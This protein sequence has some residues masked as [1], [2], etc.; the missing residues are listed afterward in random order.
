MALS[1]ILRVDNVTYRFVSMPVATNVATQLSSSYTATSTFY[2]FSAGGV[3]LNV[4]FLNP[5]AA[6]A[7]YDDFSRPG[8]YISFSAGAIDGRPHAVQLYFD[9]TAECISN[10]NT[11][12]IG[13]SR[14]NFTAP[15]GGAATALRLGAAAQNPLGTSGDY[16][17][18]SWGYLYTMVASTPGDGLSTALASSDVSRALFGS[19]G[20]VPPDAAPGTAAV[21]AGW[22]AS[23]VVWNLGVLP[24]SGAPATRWLSLFFDEILVMN[25]YGALMPPYWRRGYGVNDTTVIPLVEMAATLGAYGAATA[26]SAA[27]DQHVVDVMMAATGGDTGM[28]GVSVNEWRSGG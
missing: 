26:A 6:N 4:T 3:G 28:T 11:Q 24:A 17:K 8:S 16:V 19:T 1:G 10:A 22:M 13:W 7:T 15:G 5:L 9:N 21:S 2:T 20:G 14:T 23:I 27:W 25:F 12:I 18:I